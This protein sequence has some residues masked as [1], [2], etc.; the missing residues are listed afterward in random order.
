MTE[1]VLSGYDTDVGSGAVEESPRHTGA[2]SEGL[3]QNG[4][5]LEGCFEL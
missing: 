4:I 5:S 2:S 1:N 3:A